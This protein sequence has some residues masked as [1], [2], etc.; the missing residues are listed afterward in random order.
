MVRALV[1][2]QVIAPVA[3]RAQVVAAPGANGP[4]VVQTA[5]GLQQVNI[6]APTAAGV[7]KNVYS[8][9]DVP[10]QGVIL[11]NSSTLVNTQQAGYVN[12]NPNLARDQAARVILNQ[13]NS[14]SPSQLRG[15]LEV[16][17]KAAQ[18]VVANSAGILVDG[19]GFIN[20]TRGVLTTGTP[21]MGPDGS[22]TGYQVNGGRLVI[23][24]D[25][26]NAQ[27][28]GQVDLISRAVQVNAALHAKQL[29]VV[30]GTN[31]VDHE[32]L[33]VQKMA[34]EAGVPDV[35]DVALDVGQ[36]GGMYAQR[37]FLQGTENGVGVS[38]RGVI[39]AQAG[40]LML[41][42]EGRL[43]NAGKTL[44]SGTMTMAARALDNTGGTLAAER[45]DA[46]LGGALVNRQG[47]ISAAASTITAAVL[48]NDHGRL[49]ADTLSLTVSGDASNRSGEIKQF[50]ASDQAITVGG[51]LDNT[52]GTMAT[53]AGSLAL[54][55]GQMIN[56]GGTVSHLGDG[57]FTLTSSGVISNRNGLVG[58]LGVLSTTAAWLNNAGGELS[59]ADAL[60]VSTT[61]DFINRD[62][63]VVF[64]A[65][66]LSVSAGGDI[67]NS[68]G[69]MQ[70]TGD[71]AVS[72]S[73]AL[74]NTGG[75]LS[76]NGAHDRLNVSA[77]TIDNA[78]GQISNAGDGATEVVAATTIDNTGGT[79][80]GNG[81]LSVDAA[82]VANVAGGKVVGGGDVVLGIRDA[83]DNTGG[84]V[85]GGASLTMTQGGARV[86]N[87]DGVMESRGDVAMQLA[88]LDNTRGI[89]RSNRD[90]SVGGAMSGAGQMTA[91]RDLTVAASGDYVNASMNRLRADG[92]LTVTSTGR[93]INDGVLEA[94]GALNVRAMQIVN[95]AGG[96]INAATTR[97]SADGLLSNAGNIGGDTVRL[98]ASTV[99]NVYGVLGNDVQVDAA[100]V[101]NAGPS[102][103][104]GATR[105]LAVY[106]S[107]AV[108]NRDGALLYSMGDIEI[109]RDG[110]RDATGMLANQSSQLTNSSASIVADGNLDIAASVVDNQRTSI[111]T[112]AG[113]PQSETKTFGLWTAGLIGGDE[114]LWH[115]SRTFPEWNWNA[116]RAPISSM[117]LERLALP[118]TVEL[119]KSQVTNLDMAAKTFSL[120]RPIVETYSDAT[121][122]GQGPCDDHG[123]CANGTKTREVATQAVQYFNGIVDNGSTYRITFWPDWNPST[124][125]RPDEAISRGDLGIDQ[126]DYNELKR[127][128]T[129]TRTR[130]ELV[131]A[132]AEGKLQAQGTIRINADGGE[133]RNQSSLMTAG[134]DLIRRAQGGAVR[135]EG[136]ALQE[137]VA[138]SQVST[139]Y[140]HQKS[141]G[142]SEQ[143]DVAYPVT[144]LPPTTVA[145]LPAIAVGNQ[146][147]ETSGQT[148][149]VSS[150]D[151]NGNTV[152]NTGVTGGNG[153]GS[154][155][156][157]LPG[158]VPGLTLPGSPLYQLRPAPEHTYLVA[159]DARFTQYG[160]FISSDYVLDAL[161]LD[162][163]KTQKRLGD[164][165]YETQLVR[166][167]I[168]ALTGRTL[169]GGDADYLAQYTALLG[170]G[171]AYGKQFDLSVGVGLSDVQMQQLTTD[172]V[173]LVSQDVTL[174]DGSVQSVLVPKVYLAQASTVDLASTGA[175]VGGGSVKLAATG[176]V[177]NSGRI[178][179]DTAT[180]VLGD[181]IVNFGSVG[182]RGTTALTS[183]GD[184]RNTGGHIDGQDVALRAGR[185]LINESTTLTQTA[186][187]DTG[188]FASRASATSIGS[189][190]RISA[191]N[192]ATLVANRDVTLNAGAVASD[193]SV[194]VAAGRD[195]QLNTLAVG[196]SQTVGTRDGKN[197]GSDVV[198]QHVGSAISSGGNLTTMSGRDTTLNAATLSAGE[199]VTVIAGNDVTVNAAK[200]AYTHD[201]RSFGG[202]LKFVDSTLDESVRGTQVVAGNNV[203][204]GAGQTAVAGELLGAHAVTPVAPTSGTGNLTILGS[205]VASQGAGT[206]ALAAT[207]D[208]TIGAVS[209]THDG[210]RWQ[211]NSSSGFLSKSEETSEMRS[212]QTVAVGST[213]SADSVGA[214]AGRDLSVIGSTVV[215]T[216]D[217]ALQAGRDL[218][219]ETSENVSES[220]SFHETKRSG[221]GS[222]GGV[223][224]S[225]GKNEERHRTN[226][227]S[228]T[229]TGS[230]VGSLDGNVS[231]V[232]GRDLSVRGSD[233]MAGGDVTGIGQNVSIESVVDRV[234][235]DEAHEYKSSGF[236]LALKSPVIDAVQNVNS[237]VNAAVDSGG[238]ARVSA[239]RGYAAA[240]GAYGAVGEAG[241]VLDTLR[242]GETPEAKVELSWGSSSSKST[243]SVDSTQ[244]VASQIKAGGTAAFIATGDAA[245]GKGNV[246]VIGSSIDAKDVLLQATNQV[247]LR[248]STDTESTRS[249]NESKSGSLGVS[250]GTG[251]FGVSASASR[252]N[253]DANSDSTFQ[254]NTH[255]NAS[256]TAVIVSGGDTNVVGANVNAETVITRVGGDLNI[257]SVQDTSESSA[258]QQSM[259]GGLNL[260]QG[261]ASGSFSYSRGNA[262]ANY[263]GVVE[264]SGIQAGAGGFD[265]DVAGN[266]D[267]KGAYIASTADA[268]KN[269]LTTGT[270]TF[271]DIENHSA[272]SANSFGFGGGF[273]IANS[274][275]EKKTTGPT[276]GKN[277]GGISPMLP[278]FESGSEHAT[279]Y[280]GVSE[281]TIT[282]TDG[283]NQKQD[284][285]SLK[286]DTTD[287]NGTV[288]RTPDLQELLNDQSRLMS[289]ATAAGEAV[290]R[291]IGTYAS[292]KEDEA[293]TLAKNT[294]DPELQA[295]YLQEAENWKEG[296][297]YRALMHAAGGA[298]VAGLGGGNALGGAL[299]A[300]ATSKL[301]EAL[302]KLSAD[303]QN[304]RPTGNAD[305]DEALAQIVATGIG[306][307]V[308]GAVGGSS[309]AFTGFNTDRYNRQLHEDEKAAIRK[310][311]NGD[312]ELEK[313]LTS[314]SCYNVKCWAQFAEGSAE[315]TKYFVTDVEAAQLQ[316]EL[317]W[318]KQQKD[319]GLFLYQPWQKVADAVKSD[320]KGV[321]KDAGKFALG[322]VTAKSGAGLCATGVGCALGGW[323]MAFGASEMIEG[324]HSLY[325]RYNDNSESALNPLRFG[326]NQ[327]N[328]EWGDVAYSG[329]NFAVSVAALRVPVKLN[330]GVADGLNRPQSIFDVKVPRF[331]NDN[332]IPIIKT[333][334]PYGAT[335]GLLLLSS[336]SKGV[337]FS[338]DIKRSVVESK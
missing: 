157:T 255:I 185:D 36:L 318:V 46:T 83:L 8:Q 56:D 73:G 16:A 70:S 187:T 188:G 118:V 324:G 100:D 213:I 333:P 233:V 3:V 218:R 331:N 23:Q 175:L 121:T 280:S 18:V 321:A 287:L 55:V 92:A 84:Q 261:G 33:A 138:Q 163:Q 77:Q 93:F 171:V 40:D 22:L 277:K 61:A 217:V 155:L 303:I 310:K 326:F 329:V 239:L 49:H 115:E 184:I 28:V 81:R 308:G 279:T 152:G 199:N 42:T 212:H 126:R 320:P 62:G 68:S 63:G 160:K 78:S 143:L 229:H 226:D 195:I 11:N 267:L 29:N 53:N 210:Y 114:T 131:S 293:R 334:W 192:G 9:F 304:S 45:I 327:L 39:A 122:Q 232:A 296:G 10:R 283:A 244:N 120:T 179:S 328:S 201:A 246:D 286:R 234:H 116:G 105:R 128:V 89:V 250:F 13:V 315:R 204:V 80:G 337:E 97:L 193:G 198:T 205:T 52:G 292:K 264:Q 51:A 60:H 99:N 307:A 170:N 302:N 164:G 207:G 289:A 219:I 130:D 249:E 26:L 311:A 208:V 7:S 247:N 88:S 85:F 338:K 200:D 15:Y 43:V 17:G 168:A 65:K 123:N 281:G 151:R 20:T 54:D 227:S 35:P 2:A 5:N 6:T 87:T 58:T 156:I 94:P 142:D 76:A 30:T 71:V 317:E 230:L 222:A 57:Q 190:G 95:N 4:G 12:G 132:S 133:I 236:T 309:G 113:T 285:A 272:Y 273:S 79:L 117:L 282:L 266:T 134:G 34:G 228:V 241:K 75:R 288:I 224:I 154:A 221:L 297:D 136:I 270:L 298:I 253:G 319:A 314:A 14:Q 316:P 165:F 191:S 256:H 64:G 172:L 182:S 27:N 69:S 119:P 240:S 231:L 265:V 106:A 211:H 44:A 243:S 124:M 245:S 186:G 104:V 181:A 59:A 176:D 294:T 313:R 180:T 111:V 197:G 135:D 96:L 139:F 268:S 206:A 225:Y 306:T 258:H 189:V 101:D 238:D 129:T 166:D 325:N 86:T 41:T 31:L 107:N 262:S 25:G 147:V 203:I 299:G 312:P 103:I 146:T 257:A 237:Q 323:M 74:T 159:T 254:N 48:D 161:G 248:H 149:T 144:P 335:Q 301:G 196:Q 72:A 137:R 216:Q 194:T 178:V 263:A 235:H 284:L 336:G 177:Q 242:A 19:G 278:Q 98:K 108:V 67:D 167:Q 24:G 271:S 169:L 66:G 274:G 127:V 125:I 32:R 153:S 300:G 174:P 162:P 291:D 251:G 276:S 140:W 21:I 322:G 275:T 330:V 90:V 290:A 252:G 145:S 295:Q 269:Q 82:S 112:Q 173:W 305:V 202:T 50:G 91:G 102:A 37:I 209:E 109:A 260:S 110:V 150:V 215:G 1:L 38:N 214:T 332:L 223:G 47:S 220:S 141:G 158:G 183:L 148:I 259:S